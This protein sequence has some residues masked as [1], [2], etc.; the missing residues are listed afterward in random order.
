M[1][2]GIVGSTGWEWGMNVMC[3]SVNNII[4]LGG[5]GQYCL[6][7]GINETDKNNIEISITPNPCDE[8][9]IIEAPTSMLGG[10]LTIYNICGIEIFTQKISDAK[11]QID[12]THFPKGLFIAKLTTEST[13]IIKKIIKE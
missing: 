6:I 3:F 5:G 9:L 2:V 7:A 13:V 4:L 10:T 11:T 12:V 8:K 1:G